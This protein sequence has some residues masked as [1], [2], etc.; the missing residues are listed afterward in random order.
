MSFG[1]RLVL[2]RE[3]AHLNQKQLA[4]A[5][6]ITPTRLNYWEKNK[7]Q[8]DVFMIKALASTLNVSADYLIGNETNR[9]SFSAKEQSHIKKYRLLNEN[10]QV[11]TDDYMDDLLKVDQYRACDKE[12]FSKPLAPDPDI[13]YDA[14]IEEAELEIARTPYARVAAY[15][16][17]NMLVKEIVADEEDEDEYA[18]ENDTIKKPTE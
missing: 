10:G 11:K 9:S 14:A 8:P 16:G 4:E 3:K 1:E 12:E 18:E 15:G 7:R 17:K 6:N 2:A 5:L 13:D